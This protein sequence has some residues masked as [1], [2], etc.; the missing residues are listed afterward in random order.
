M[1]RGKVRRV[2]QPTEQE[3]VDHLKAVH[4]IDVKPPAAYIE[5]HR[6]H[7]CVR[8]HDEDVNTPPHTHPWD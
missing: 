4:L 7:H 1:R 8:L 6:R 3:L 5:G 2:E